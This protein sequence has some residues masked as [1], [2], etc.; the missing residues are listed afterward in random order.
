M[1]NFKNSFWNLFIGYGSS[2]QR[3]TSVF[4]PIFHAPLTEGDYRFED[5]LELNKI[6]EELGPPDLS[7]NSY[8]KVQEFEKQIKEEFS[9]RFGR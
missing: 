2:I 9:K 6:Y 8:E 1:N 4:N 5:I 3:V 7:E